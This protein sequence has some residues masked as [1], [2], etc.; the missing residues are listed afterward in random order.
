[1]RRRA[2]GQH[3]Q[4]Q[5]GQQR[6]LKERHERLEGLEDRTE[7]GLDDPGE[8][9]AHQQE[10]H[11]QRLPHP[12]VVGIRPP[13]YE[14]LVE[15]GDDQR[16][17]RIDVGIEV[18]QHA[19]Q[20]GAYHNPQDARGQKIYHQQR[21]DPI[22]RAFAPV[23]RIAEPVVEQGHTDQAGEHQQ[24]GKD[25]LEDCTED[26]G[27]TRLVLAA[28]PERA[29]DNRLVADPVGRS[30]HKAKSQQDRGPGKSGMIRG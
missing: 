18:G 12:E 25:Q 2:A 4:Q 10:Y 1:M 19:R 17:G 11:D 21:Q 8:H 30:E 14:R 6:A 15:V 7:Y 27:R 28:G 29:L 13:S 5:Q 26:I 3:A 9:D 24:H 23:A 22:G 16:A 20:K